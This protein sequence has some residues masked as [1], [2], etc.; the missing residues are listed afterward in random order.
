MLYSCGAELLTCLPKTSELCYDPLST[1]RRKGKPELFRGET[2]FQHARIRTP[3]ERL[4]SMDSLARGAS[5]KLRVVTN[6]MKSVISPHTR[7]LRR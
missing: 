5:A 2:L 3:P 1:Y 6:T 7:N 4:Y